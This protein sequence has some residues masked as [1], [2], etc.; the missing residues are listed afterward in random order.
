MASC[1]VDALAPARSRAP[2]GSLTQIV[3]GSAGAEGGVT[4]GADLGIGRDAG[5]D[6]GEAWGSMVGEAEG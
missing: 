3:N 5:H 2:S 6:V 4:V 1:A